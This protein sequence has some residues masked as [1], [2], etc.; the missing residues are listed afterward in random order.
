MRQLLIGALAVHVYDYDQAIRAL[1][2]PDPFDVA[3]LDHD[4]FYRTIDRTGYD[5]AEYIIAMPRERRPKFIVVH[6]VNDVGAQRMVN[7]LQS[8]GCNAVREP[9]RAG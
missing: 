9:W 6:S 7:L 8:A 3:Y 4:L 5:V 1:E 2:L